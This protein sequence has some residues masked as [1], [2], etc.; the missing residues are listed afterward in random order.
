[1]LPFLS[2]SSESLA[3]LVRSFLCSPL[4]SQGQS[5]IVEMM[6]GIFFPRWT[7]YCFSHLQSCFRSSKVPPPPIHDPSPRSYLRD[8]PAGNRFFFILESINNWARISAFFLPPS[9]P[10]IPFEKP[11]LAICRFPILSFTLHFA[12]VTDSPLLDPVLSSFF[13]SFLSPFFFPYHAAPGFIPPL[14]RE[15]CRVHRGLLE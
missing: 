11:R 15:S 12:M 13:L 6:V 3:F 10:S 2:H 4:R 14:D 9:P 8:F 5:T 7:Y 1:L